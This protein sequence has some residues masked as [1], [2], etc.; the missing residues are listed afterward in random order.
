MKKYI[1]WA[2]M[3]VFGSLLNG[4]AAQE[5]MG[6]LSAGLAVPAGSSSNAPK[7]SE[8]FTAGLR[9]VYFPGRPALPLTVMLD[10]IHW[11][12]S[13]S[14]DRSAVPIDEGLYAKRYL[15]FPVTA[16]LLLPICSVGKKHSWALTGYATVGAYWRN[17]NCQRMAAPGVMDDM[18]EHGWGV[19]WKVGFDLAR[20]FEWFVGVSYTAF[21]N[22]FGSGG[23]P[24][25]A[26]T[27]AVVDGVRRSQPTLD[28]F[29]QGFI[30]FEIGYWLCK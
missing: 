29:G 15:C 21:G 24:L 28:G 17:I 30:K 22:P 20:R 27:G 23:D 18:E 14:P 19:A 12:Y 1:L 10:G 26:G 3:T 13:E 5:W 8:S 4:V 9:A 7:L 2:L 6:G 25:P 11:L 16:G